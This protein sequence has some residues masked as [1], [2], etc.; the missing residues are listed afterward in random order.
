[1]LYVH[2]YLLTDMCSYLHTYMH[3]YVCTSISMYARIT[4]TLYY[5]LTITLFYQVV[6]QTA[7]AA[8][9]AVIEETFQSLLN[10]NFDDAYKKI[11]NVSS[12]NF[13]F[14]S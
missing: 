12:W 3:M 1:M 7:G 8:M 11:N 13:I 9:P 6:Y 5:S 4:I 10:D 14:V 2:V